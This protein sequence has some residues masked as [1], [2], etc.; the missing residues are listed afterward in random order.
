MKGSN[1]VMGS[2]LCHLCGNI[3]VISQAI[4]IVLTRAFHDLYTYVQNTSFVNKL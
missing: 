2:D 1:E 4:G 3:C